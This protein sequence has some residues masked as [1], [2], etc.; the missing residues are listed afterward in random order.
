MLN[1]S[2]FLRRLPACLTCGTELWM[3]ADSD[4]GGENKRSI[5]KEM[6]MERAK[7]K[8]FL[9]ARPTR[10]SEVRAI[11]HICLGLRCERASSLEEDFF[12]VLG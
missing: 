12:T 11:R 6:E 10:V 8:G 5:G 3:D 9:S 1:A 4:I 7:K 2:N